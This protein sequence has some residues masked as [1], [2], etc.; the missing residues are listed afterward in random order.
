MV[1]GEKIRGTAG[2]LYLF[3]Q[4]GEG[5]GLAAAVFAAAAG[6]LLALV[7]MVL[8]RSFLKLATATGKTEKVRCKE[9]MVREK[10]V[11]GAFLAKEL[12]RFVSSPN[13]I[14]NCGIPILLI[15]VSAVLLLIKGPL[16]CE[17]LGEVFTRMP[18]TAAVLLC[19]ALCMLSAMNDMAAPSVSLEGKSLWIP[20]S[21]P[22]EPKLVLRV[23]ASMQIFL[24]GIP[25]LF[26]SVCTA[27]IV[28][29]SVTVRLLTGIMPLVCTVFSALCGVTVGVKMPLLSWTSETAP[30]KQSGAVMISL[31]GGWIISAAFGVLYL[32]A[33]YKIGGVWYLLLWTLLLAVMSVIL[34]RWLDTRGAEE[35]S[36]L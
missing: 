35:F 22:V 29:A 25:M 14:L 30:I 36:K 19:A 28:D 2:I 23:K 27:V 9:K 12:G 20:Q 1:Y 24:S 7:G 8:S 17:V 15:P 6:L 33:G 16:I 26:A 13:Y 11:F 18:D 4:I 31:F 21:L 34:L 3:G 10:S 32:L 5:N